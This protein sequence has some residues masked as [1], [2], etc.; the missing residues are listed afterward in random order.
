MRLT[1][2][3]TY[4]DVFNRE[5]S[6]ISEDM[7]GSFSIQPNHQRSDDIP[8]SVLPPRKVE[9]PKLI[10]AP[11]EQ[12]VRTPFIQAST[13]K[14]LPALK[15][16]GENPPERN[17]DGSDSTGNM[18][19]SNSKNSGKGKAS[20]SDKS[21][22]RDPKRKNLRGKIFGKS[23]RPKSRDNSGKGRNLADNGKKSTN[24]QNKRRSKSASKSGEIQIEQAAGVTSSSEDSSID[25]E[26][27][28]R[29]E[30]DDY[31]VELSHESEI[32][33]EEANISHM[34]HNLSIGNLTEA[35]ATQ[36]RLK[37][38]MYQSFAIHF[39]SLF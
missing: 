18:K 35:I 3:S 34:L 4:Q 27:A 30:D 13:R 28:W 8:L 5:M 9:V 39:I 22:S 23:E 2:Q 38:G 32:N 10:L 33:Q 24:S 14:N 31:I 20:G 7:Y 26:D 16:E 15:E 36:E 1:K 19:D 29:S 21:K 12:N 17:K 37:D 6:E 25:G 11:S